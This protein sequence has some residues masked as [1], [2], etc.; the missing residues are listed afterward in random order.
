ML[1]SKD[2]KQLQTYHFYL[3]YT[4]ASPISSFLTTFKDEPLPG[5]QPLATAT[6]HCEAKKL[7]PC[8]FCTQCFQCTD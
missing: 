4:T 3:I 5:P 1:Q 2:I 6:L 8:S 7:H